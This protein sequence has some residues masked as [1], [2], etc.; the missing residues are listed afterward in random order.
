MVRDGIRLDPQ[1]PAP[2]SN[3]PALDELLQGIAVPDVL[4]LGEL[5]HFIR[6]KVDDFPLSWLHRLAAQR[7]LVLAEELGWSDGYRIDR[8]LRTGTR[9]ELERIATFGY[10][11]DRREDRDDSLSGV[12]NYD[13]FPRAT[14]RAEHI[15]FD[16][17]LHAF[18]SAPRF[19]GFDIDVFAGGG[20]VDI[21]PLVQA[22]G[23]PEELQKALVPVRGESASARARS[24]RRQRAYGSPI[25]PVHRAPHRR[26]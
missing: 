7:R 15:R 3:L 12:L 20:Y 11:G 23:L 14:F 17:A 16:E 25:E 5:N 4:F 26:R 2:Q 24:P 19:F 9:N 22:L 10:S 8:F 18:A 13:D 6:E 21:A 1:T